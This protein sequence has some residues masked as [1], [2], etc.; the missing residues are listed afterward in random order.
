[1]CR[2][3]VSHKDYSFGDAV[4]PR[5]I[6]GAWVE[7]VFVVEASTDCVALYDLDAHRCFG[8]KDDG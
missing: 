3:F 7:R 5:A 4:A 6:G 8:S 2:T 1:M